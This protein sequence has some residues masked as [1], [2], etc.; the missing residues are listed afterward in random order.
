MKGA[1]PGDLRRAKRGGRDHP[2]VHL[3]FSPSLWAFPNPVAFPEGPG[4]IHLTIFL[5]Q[6]SVQDLCKAADT[7]AQ[8]R[9][10]PEGLQVSRPEDDKDSGLNVVTGT[11]WLKGIGSQHRYFVS[12]L[13]LVSFQHQQL[14]TRNPGLA[15]LDGTPPQ[16]GI[17]VHPLLW[18]GLVLAP[19]ALGVGELSYSQGS[20]IH[21]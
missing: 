15:Q 3:H 1:E 6:L 9:V 17:L 4:F 10:W 21:C 14:F 12:P 20:L 7:E 2:K 13:W 18:S 16:V 5:L 11:I 8:I 19:I